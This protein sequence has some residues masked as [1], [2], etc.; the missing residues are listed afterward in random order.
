VLFTEGLV[1][2]QVRVTVCTTEMQRIATHHSATT[3]IK[4]EI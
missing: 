3:V 1:N 2:I 4:N